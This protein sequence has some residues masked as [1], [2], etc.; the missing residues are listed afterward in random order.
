M[1]DDLRD[2]RAYNLITAIQ[3]SG[4]TDKISIITFVIISSR[5]LNTIFHDESFS[6]LPGGEL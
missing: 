3:F 2:L 1:P 6:F 5:E 4:Y